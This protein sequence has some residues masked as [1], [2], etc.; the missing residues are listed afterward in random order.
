MASSGS[1][2]R[3]AASDASAYPARGRRLER[4]PL[5][6]PLPRRRRASCQVHVSIVGHDEGSIAVIVEVQQ[7]E[8]PQ[9]QGL[10]CAA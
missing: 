9:L 8:I 4:D 5:A 2:Q 6:I 10:T 3:G 1:E 7:K